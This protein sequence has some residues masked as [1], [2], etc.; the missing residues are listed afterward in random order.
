V[1]NQVQIE[2]LIVGAFGILLFL[3]AML[4]LDYLFRLQQ[5]R[6]LANFLGREGARLF[7]GIIAAVLVCFA[8]W[9]WLAKF[10]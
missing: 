8:I 1:V 4:N 2:L 7:I 9:V 5:T 10:G 3:S 6:T